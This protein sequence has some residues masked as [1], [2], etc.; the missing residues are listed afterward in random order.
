MTVKSGTEGKVYLERGKFTANRKSKKRDK[1]H[2]GDKIQKD[3]KHAVTVPADPALQGPLPAFSAPCSLPLHMAA[4]S[5][6]VFSERG[7]EN[8]TSRVARG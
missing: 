3:G 2:S 7:K 6:A 4:V 5:H 1:Y 8:S